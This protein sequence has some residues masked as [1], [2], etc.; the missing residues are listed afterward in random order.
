MMASRRD[1][2]LLRPDTIKSDRSV[3]PLFCFFPPRTEAKS[4]AQPL[5]SCGVPLKPI[6]VP[7]SVQPRSQ[8][9]TPPHSCG[10]CVHFQCFATW[11]AYRALHT[12]A[13]ISR[14]PTSHH[15][16]DNLHS[17]ENL[18]HRQCHRIYAPL[19]VDGVNA[20]PSYLPS[21]IRTAGH[22]HTTT[23]L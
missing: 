23:G 1:K 22:S 12:F 17:L 9:D 2:P 20:M 3:C 21:S 10:S 6:E 14:K 18:F 13:T 5:D 11:H 16:T 7:K 4:K 15:P 8:R 19:P